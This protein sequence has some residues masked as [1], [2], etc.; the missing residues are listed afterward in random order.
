MAGPLLEK[1][2]GGGIFPS[3]MPLWPHVFNK[4]K[5]QRC[6]LD[7]PS[8]WMDSNVPRFVQLLIDQDDTGWAIQSRSL[9][10]MVRIIRPVHV[11]SDP[12]D[13]YTIGCTEVLLDQGLRSWNIRME[14]KMY[15]QTN[16]I[17][18]RYIHCVFL[19]KFSREQL[20]TNTHQINVPVWRVVTNWAWEQ[21]S[22]KCGSTYPYGYTPSLG[23][24]VF[25]FHPFYML[26]FLSIHAEWLSSTA[27]LP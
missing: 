7:L 12:V 2:L 9:Y 26:L 24:Y 11:T 13:G 19:Q 16:K 22:G 8:E 1:F 25:N 10:G 20:T 15:Q 14:R 21:D 27:S 6:H 4:V 17:L 23:F 3:L 5:K 18:K